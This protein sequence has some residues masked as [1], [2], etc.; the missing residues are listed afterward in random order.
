M[1]TP[2]IG[3]VLGATLL[4]VVSVAYQP[5]NT[6]QGTPLALKTGSGAVLRAPLFSNKPQ[7][8]LWQ[9]ANTS[10]GTPQTLRPEL[11]LPAGHAAPFVAAPSVQLVINTSQGAP[12]ALRSG[13][14]QSPLVGPA[15]ASAPAAASILRDTSL[16]TPKTLR[17]DAQPPLVVEPVPAAQSKPYQPPDTSRGTPKTLYG[18]AQPPIIAELSL[19]V[20]AVS[21]V[22]DTTRGSPLALIA[23]GFVQPPLVVEPG[24]QTP[25]G[26]AI[27]G[28]SSR[29]MPAPMVAQALTQTPF[30]PSFVGTPWVWYQPLDT[31]RSTAKVLFADATPPILP[32]LSLSAP[33]INR[34][35]DTSKCSPQ[36]LLAA[37]IQPPLVQEPT[38]GTSASAYQPANTS[39][40]TPATLLQPIVAGPPLAPSQVSTPSTIATAPNT[41]QSSNLALLSATAVSPPPS[42]PSYTAVPWSLWQP[43]D[44]SQESPPVLIQNVQPA[45][46]IVTVPDVGSGKPKRKR[47]YVEIDGQYFEVRNH[48]HAVEILTALH[49]AAKETAPAAV[50]AA[51]EQ[52]QAP[53]IPRMVVVKP[54]YSKE[55]F[56]QLQAQVDAA[57]ARIAAVYRDAIAAQR[58]ADAQYAAQIVAKAQDD[59]DEDDIVTL[60]SMGI[61]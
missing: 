2:L 9:P 22:Q 35:A 13:F 5:L 6:S 33:S 46:P 12:L 54:D 27:F 56:Q 44:T 53:V 51:M 29:G 20:P 24:P 7:R 25:Q 39:L 11:V 34:V 40:G 1:A 31:S 36:T 42:P 10:Q 59:M 60:M 41:S 52:A 21:S 28:D 30:Q 14:I 8:N 26:S 48:Q 49:E 17:P 58:V 61:L 45:P 55:F 18:D 43:A 16:G 32:E 50:K 37:F 3:A 4:S 15:I 19:A 47:H 38:A 23:A 57:N